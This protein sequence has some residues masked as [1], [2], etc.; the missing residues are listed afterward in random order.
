MRF[1]YISVEVWFHSVDIGE[2][3]IRFI[4]FAHFHRR[5][6]AIYVTTKKGVFS[7]KTFLS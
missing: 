4:I 7:D 6:S 3:G 1:K 2:K 5:R